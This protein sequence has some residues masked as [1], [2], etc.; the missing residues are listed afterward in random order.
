MGVVV[1]LPGDQVFVPPLGEGVQGGAG[2]SGDR[3]LI[4]VRP[5][6]HPG[7]GDKGVQ[8]LVHLQEETCETLCIA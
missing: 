2:G 6:L 8:R 4:P 5:H 7:E 3:N 1:F